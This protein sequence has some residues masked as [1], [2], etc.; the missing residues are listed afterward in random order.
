MIPHQWPRAI[1]ELWSHDGRREPSAG[2]R[3]RRRPAVESLESRQLLASTTVTPISLTSS[4]SFPDRGRRGAGRQGLVHR[5]RRQ[6][7]RRHRPGHAHGRPKPR[8]CRPPPPARTASPSAPTA[9][10]G[11]PSRP[12]T[13]SAG[14]TRRRMA[15]TEFAPARRPTAGPTG[16][17]AGPDGNLWFT[18]SGGDKIGRINPTDEASP[19]S[20][21]RPPTRSPTGSRP[22]PTATSGSPSTP[23]TRSAGSTRRR[24]SSP[25]SPPCR[26]P[27]RSR[28][29]S[30]PGPTATSGSPSPAATRIGRST[31]RPAPSPSSPLPTGHLRPDR[32]HGRPRRQPLVHRAPDTANKVGTINPT[33]GGIADFP[34]GGDSAQPVGI[35]SGP[36]GNVWLRPGGVGTHVA[37]VTPPRTWRSTARLPGFV[38]PAKTFSMSVSLHYLT[39][40][41]DTAFNG[42]SP[43]ALANPGGAALGGTLT[44]TAKDG[45]ATFSGLSISQAGQYQIVASAD[46]TT[47]MMSPTVTVAVPPTIIA[48]KLIYAGKG[49]RARRRL[50]A[51]LQLGDGPDPGGEHDRVHPDPEHAPRPPAHRPGGRRAG[52]L[53]RDG[54]R[55]DAD[56]RRQAEVRPGGQAGGLGHDPG[57]AH[58]GT[59]VRSTAGTRARSA[60]TA[61]SSSRRRARPSRDESRDEPGR[62]RKITPAPR[63]RGRAGDGRWTAD[64]SPIRSTRVRSAGEVGCRT[65]HR[66]A[67]EAPGGPTGACRRLPQ[68]TA[69][70][71]G[72]TGGPR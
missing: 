55:G 2:T 56:P 63:F 69:L 38:A 66:R 53:R 41:V 17:T 57:R 36:D 46:P 6:Q 23:A 1:S 21:S 67:D 62:L 31:R 4:T 47:T 72:I 9:T 42:R 29:G 5:V 61:P 37:V 22:G 3:R 68:L 43:L 27:A 35:A 45:V 19:S 30:P 34:I 11:S 14:S 18:E 71:D 12:A 44:A 50:R 26:R 15:I 70:S 25:S 52:G 16:I 59:G 33:T 28:T 51:R 10:S 65:G 49:R 20:P 48:E 24:T 7:D 13:R 39:G 64:D 40:P 54:A 60:T 8:P 58:D 32:D